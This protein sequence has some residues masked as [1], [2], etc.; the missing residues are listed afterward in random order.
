MSTGTGNVCLEDVLLPVKL[1]SLWRSTGTYL[2]V[3]VPVL[4]LEA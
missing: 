4:G 1:Q 2:P 3:T